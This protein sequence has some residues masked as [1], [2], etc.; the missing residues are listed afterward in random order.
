MLLIRLYVN[1]TWRY[2]SDV[3][4]MA[5]VS[6]T[7]YRQYL[8]GVIAM[9]EIRIASEHKWGGH[10]RMEYGA[11]TLSPT[12][13]EGAWPPPVKMDIRVCY[14]TLGES[15]EQVLLMG[16]AYLQELRADSVVCGLYSPASPTVVTDELFYGGLENLF[17]THC[18]T[19]GLTLRLSCYDSLGVEWFG[20]PNPI[21]EYKAA[22]DR[23]LINL[24]SEVAAWGGYRFYIDGTD[25]VLVHT[26][27]SNGP[28]IALGA[29]EILSTNY[30][31]S[32]PYVRYEC[33]GEIFRPLKWRLTFNELQNPSRVAVAFAEIRVRWVYENQWH[34]A[35]ALACED[36]TPLYPLAN[37]WDNNVNSYWAAD[38][39]IGDTGRQQA[40]TF[41]TSGY[42][43][44][45]Y[46]LTA[47]NDTFFDQAAVDWRLDAW[48]TNTARW[49]KVQ[50][51]ETQPWSTGSTQE[52]PAPSAQW[53]VAI[54]GG[55]GYGDVCTVAPSCN[56]WYADKVAAL[57]QVKA[58]VE[59]RRAMVQLPLE[60]GRIPKIGQRVT[61][62]DETLRTSTAVDMKV[63]TIT[64]NFETHTC[65][66]EG[67]ATLT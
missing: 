39:P 52:F 28:V 42:Y 67:E 45:T 14:G 12:V 48:D 24:L 59:M 36:A 50:D 34:N 38:F 15:D 23:Q 40:L 16:S 10:V 11:I 47:R 63:A 17:A 30:P 5:H 19:L 29:H 26:S 57:E 46:K 44:D 18:A 13:F 56:W 64:Y 60:A 55:Y 9:D 65:V 3:D 32:A 7:T 43:I 49:R 22:G 37:L 25:L 35:S 27:Y 61:Y 8:A 62:T 2:I 21:I 54:A 20:G 66:I 58:I 1:G 31:G 4:Q 6:G 53:T 51:V 33:E 41:E